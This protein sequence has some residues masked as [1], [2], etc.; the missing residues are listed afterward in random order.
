MALT[1]TAEL[2]PRFLQGFL[3][4]VPSPLC[5]MGHRQEG[6]FALAYCGEPALAG[7]WVGPQA[8][9]HQRVLGESPEEMENR[10]AIFPV[11]QH[12]RTW[13]ERGR[14]LAEGQLP[15]LV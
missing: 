13:Y 10:A 2:W 3:A 4:K 8:G 5:P 11:L 9:P 14:W 12:G 1:T 15:I 6:G 7:A